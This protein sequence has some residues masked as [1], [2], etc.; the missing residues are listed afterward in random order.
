M[1][2]RANTKS[3]VSSHAVALN[4]PFLQSPEIP[5]DVPTLIGRMNPDIGVQFKQGRRVE[6]GVLS[7]VRRARRIERGAYIDASRARRVK[8][9]RAMGG[10]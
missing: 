9:K 3:E 6:R 4:Q 7:A 5:S 1:Y 2:F 8:R 10:V